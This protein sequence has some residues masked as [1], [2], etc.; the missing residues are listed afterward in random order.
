M[1]FNFSIPRVLLL[2]IFLVIFAALG[3]FN[4]PSVAPD[5]LLDPRRIAKAWTY[6]V[7]LFISGAVCASVVDHFVGTL[8]RSNIR[9]LYIILGVAVMVG[10]S[11]WI[12]GLHGASKGDSTDSNKASILS[13]DPL[14]FPAVMTLISSTRSRS[15][16]PSQA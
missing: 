15:L 2:I 11:I 6:C 16:A 12:R 10:A 5:S 13:P 14:P 8:D 9:I 4:P 3:G 1:E 7:L